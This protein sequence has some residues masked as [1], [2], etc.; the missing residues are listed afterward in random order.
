MSSQRKS[1]RRKRRTWSLFGELQRIPSE[2]EIV[3]HKLHYHFR[4]EPA[5][6]EIDPNVPINNWYLKYREGSPFQVDDWENFRDPF[7]L[8][9]RS[10]IQQQKERETYI[11]NLIDEFERKDSDTHLSKNWVEILERLYIPSRFSTHVL[12]MVAQYIGQMAPSAYI[13]NMVHFQ[14]ADECRRIQRSAYRTKAL[15]L[16]HNPD[17]ASSEKTRLIWEEDSVWQP[18]REFLEKLLVTYD[19]GEAFAG[20]NLVAK[21]L[22]DELMLNELGKLAEL[23]GDRLLTYINGDL[24]LDSQRSRDWTQALVKYAIEHRSEN[25]QLLQQWVNKWIP[26]AHRAVEELATVFNNAPHPNKPDEVT[27]SV[28]GLHQAF[29]DT[30][31]GC[32]QSL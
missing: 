29:L 12:Q 8:T 19:W 28:I 7:Q 21:P 26:L 15:S 20:L 25:Q 10:Y 6:F 32:S 13:S 23:N 11:D 14:G 17:L 22:Y 30:T 2:Y 3:T 16:V 31:L 27:Q 5:P 18:M 9:Y 24:A 4:R 1:Q